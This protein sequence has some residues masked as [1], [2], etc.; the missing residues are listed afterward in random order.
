MP[1]ATPWFLGAYVVLNLLCCM[2]IGNW[3]CQIAI[4]CSYSVKWPAR[5]ICSKMTTDDE[6]VFARISLI[7]EQY[8]PT[9]V[10]ETAHGRNVVLPRQYEFSNKYALEW[11]RTNFRFAWILQ[12]KKLSR[13]PQGK[14]EWTVS[15]KPNRSGLSTRL[16]QFTSAHC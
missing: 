14:P 10:N 12:F 5:H 4:T 15:T 1:A 6:L 2:Y 16:L 3:H 7:S 11:N 13:G 8:H 9:T